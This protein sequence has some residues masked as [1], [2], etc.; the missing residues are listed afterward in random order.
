M[1]D[2]ARLARNYL[3]ARQ[4]AISSKNAHEQA[5]YVLGE[6]RELAEAMTNLVQYRPYRTPQQAADLRTNV[7]H[8]I[9]DVAIALANLA[10]MLGVTVEDCIAKKTEHDRGRG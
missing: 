9:A 2:L 3:A 8:E 10:D 4:H 7:E 5:R 1:T 6:A